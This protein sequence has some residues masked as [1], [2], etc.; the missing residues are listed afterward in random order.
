MA[1]I[2]TEKAQ[3]NRLEIA[4][5]DY[6]TVRRIDPS[7]DSRGCDIVGDYVLR[8]QV[9]YMPQAGLQE[10]FLAC[11]SNLIFLCGES[12]MGK[13]Q[14]C[15]AQIATPNGFVAM[16]ELKVGD[17]ICGVD[18]GVQRVV[19]V[20]ERGERDVYKLYFHDGSS[21]E[22][23]DEHLWK[24]SK[25]KANGH[26]YGDWEIGDFADI[27]RCFDSGSKI[28]IPVC[29]PTF[30]R[31]NSLA[32][33]PYI[34]G[35]LLG[36]GC[37]RN[38]GILFS[39]ADVELLEAFEKKGYHCQHCANYD[40][41]ISG[42]DILKNMRELG[43]IGKRSW[44]KFI[45]KDYLYSDVASRFSLLQGLIDTDGSI[46]KT[47]IVEYD[48]VSCQLAE[49]VR[50]LVYSL[51]GI[52]IVSKKY[53][54]YTYGGEL[55]DGKLCYRLRINLGENRF[56]ICKL[57]RKL[58]R[59]GAN[60]FKGWRGSQFRRRLV[61]YEYLGK[62]PCRCIKVSNSDNLYL[63]DDFIVTH[64]TYGMFLKALCGLGKEGYTCRFISVRLQDSKKGGS[65]F[66]D[67][68]QV[69]GNFGN[70]QY[71][72]SDY[73]TFVW[74]QWNNSMQLIHS[75]FNVDNPAEY[76]E[77]KD[78]AKKN[79]ASLIMIDEATEMRSFKMF[80]YW[81]SRN[82]DS[83]GMIPQM[84]LSFNYVYGHFTNNMLKQAGYFTD[85]W[86]FRPEMNGKTRYF[87]VM[88]DNE[89]SI[90][91][92]DS[93]EEVNAIAHIDEMITEKERKAGITYKQII[94][95]FTAFSGESADNLKLLAATRG[96]N[97]GNLHNVGGKEREI[98][99]KGYAGP[100]D[101][102]EI[103]ISRKM[104]DSMWDNPI[105]DDENMYATMDISSGKD[106]NDKCPMLIWKGLQVIALELFRGN[107]KEIAPWIQTKLAQYNVP[108]TNFAYDATGHGYWM[109]GLTNGVP[110]TANKRPIQE[111]DEYGNPVMRDDFFNCRSQLM[112]KL[113]VLIKSGYISIAI[114][115]WQ[116]FP[117]GAKG[118]NRQLI[119]ALYDQSNVFITTTRNKKIYYRNKE[120]YRSK[121]KS[122]PDLIDAMSLRMAFELDAR[123]KKQPLPETDE[124]AY[125]ALY[126]I[127]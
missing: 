41:R 124:Y 88:G 126:S 53:P 11:D 83:S 125:D 15:T 71:N 18:G 110:I 127:W 94:K 68:V 5:N 82:R 44:D 26:T 67:A 52:C 87:Y 86:Y 55:R 22:C 20:Y 6:P 114:D 43:L 10:R 64:N 117:I 27:K 81:F 2:F 102:E 105:N 25:T 76:E 32:V 121:F 85:D 77:F 100:V 116:E 108:I 54:K 79:Q 73:P 35:L 17:E 8:D 4:V 38:D 1:F 72:A 96:Q 51:G 34:L 12:Q 21:T 19:N 57:W 58:C 112:G 31:Q 42:N 75:N 13:A 107:P 66:R 111:I 3:E 29:K 40:Y 93:Y 70:C 109:Q 30:F 123:P 98:L 90:I 62:K 47:G 78:Y 9:D 7:V 46:S 118:T 97:I 65:I 39:T 14:P 120:E 60:G 50:M 69:C 113:E 56:N 48:T 45:P 33:P 63:T 115:K 95:S 24:Y 28:G 104:I 99:K 61:K 16:G 36:N 74:P 23:C 103:N 49:D 59:V 119:E 84:V 91:W 92:G 80:K 37:L 89:D 122:S 101:N 106:E